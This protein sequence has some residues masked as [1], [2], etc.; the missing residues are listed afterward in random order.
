MEE[1][2]KDLIGKTVKIKENIYNHW[3][4]DSGVIIAETR[5]MYKDKPILV[6]AI[7]DKKVRFEPEELEVV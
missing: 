5:G 6:V 1:N 2:L 7:A 4:G 3:V